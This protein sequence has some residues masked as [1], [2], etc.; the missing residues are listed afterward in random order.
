V[1]YAHDFR[2]YCSDFCGSSRYVDHG[3]GFQTYSV[4]DNHWGHYFD[5]EFVHEENKTMMYS[6]K[7]VNKIDIFE[8][9]K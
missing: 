6:L 4:R 9:Q 7:S 2:N 1:S 3:L 5:S 8:G